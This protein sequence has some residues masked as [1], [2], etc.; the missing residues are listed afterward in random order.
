MKFKIFSLVLLF[1]AFVFASCGDDEDPVGDDNPIT[2]D[3]G[4]GN[5]DPTFTSVT[6]LANAIGG[7]GKDSMTFAGQALYKRQYDP[8]TQT[9]G[10]EEDVTNDPNIQFTKHS[11]WI[12]YDSYNSDRFG[13]PV[14]KLKLIDPMG[15]TGMNWEF[16]PDVFDV[17]YMNVNEEA[18][19]RGLRHEWTDVKVTKSTFEYS[20]EWQSGGTIYIERYVWTRL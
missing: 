17:M 8:M 11:M 12:K 7:D 6:E 5:G 13:Y 4:G 19:P 2:D 15:K 1:G 3:D 20:R 10:P 9:Y 14:G 16:K 18:P